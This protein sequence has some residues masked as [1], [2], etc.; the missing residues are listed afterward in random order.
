[1]FILIFT[2]ILT[3]CNRQ[4]PSSSEKSSLDLRQVEQVKGNENK[5]QVLIQVDAS[6]EK[7]DSLNESFLN[8]LQFAGS[9]EVEV[10]KIVNPEFKQTKKIPSQLLIL[11][12]LL[13]L[14]INRRTA[15]RADSIFYNCLK[16]DW[17]KKSEKETHILRTCEKKPQAIALIKRNGITEYEIHFIQ[18][19]WQSVIGDSAL[20]NQ[21]DKVCRLIISNKKVHELTCENT[22]L[23]SGSQASLEEIRLRTYTFSRTG[24]NQIVVAGGRYKDLLERSKINIIV[25]EDGKIKFKEIETAVID[26]FKDEVKQT[27]PAADFIPEPPK[28]LAPETEENKGR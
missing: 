2:L 27:H 22:L 3:S 16:L 28:G 20:L 5:V 19:E 4:S 1:M 18:S 23:T 12:Q 25:P 15:I 8:Y 17:I 7:N 26:D 10:L 13:E 21:K 9:V 24:K 14:K 11:A 6:L